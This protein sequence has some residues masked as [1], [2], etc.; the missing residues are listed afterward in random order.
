MSNRSNKIRLLAASLGLGGCVSAVILAA[1]SA[2]TNTTGSSSATQVLTQTSVRSSARNLSLQ[3][4][5]LD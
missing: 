1:G 5:A 2:W 3:P 4:E